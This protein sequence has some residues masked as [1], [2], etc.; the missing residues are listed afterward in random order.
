MQRTTRTYLDY[1]HGIVQENIGTSATTMFYMNSISSHQ[2]PTSNVAVFV[3]NLCLATLDPGAFV[4]LLKTKYK[5]KIKGDGVISYHLGCNFGWDK[6]GTLSAEP[7]QYIEKML[8]ATNFFSV[9]LPKHT[10]ETHSS[11]TTTQ[12]STNRQSLTRTEGPSTYA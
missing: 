11:Q 7:R 10:T 5:F 3:D 9:N 2:K 8:E 6:D 1:L 4:S 12:S